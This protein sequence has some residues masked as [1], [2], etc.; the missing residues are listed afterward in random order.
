[1][2][3]QA[4]SKQSTRPSEVIGWL[5]SSGHQTLINNAARGE[6]TTS[7]SKGTTQGQTN[8]KNKKD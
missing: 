1:V 6:Q 2:A 5:G 3:D 4:K 7:S 8:K